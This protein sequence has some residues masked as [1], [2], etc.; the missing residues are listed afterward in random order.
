MYKNLVTKEG[1]SL[2]S[3]WYEVFKELAQPRIE[4]LANLTSSIQV[5]PERP[6]EKRIIR[7]VLDQALLDKDLFLTRTTSS[8]IFPPIWNPNKPRMLLY[9]RYLNVFPKL[10]KLSSWN[11]NGMYFERLINYCSKQNEGNY[12]VNQLEHIINTFKEGNHR[13]TA[14]QA[15]IFDP[16]KDHTDQRRRGFPCLQHV[17]FSQ[18]KKD[19]LAIT[20]I[21]SKQFIFDRAYGNY[22]GLYNLGIF[23]AHEM[24]LSLSSVNCYACHA[25]LGSINKGEAIELLNRLDQGLNTTTISLEGE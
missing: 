24:G 25:E 15:T 6:L 18:D 3:I 13:Q 4:G 1:D 22:L 20:G 10:K 2:S 9:Q 7:D 23:M 5:R 17:I 11:Y 19:H 21:Y 12:H 14:L 8:T 16:S